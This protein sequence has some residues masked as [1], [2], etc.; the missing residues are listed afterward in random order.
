MSIKSIP[1]SE[2]RVAL[3]GAG[4]I[5]SIH[6]QALTEFAK[7]S[8]VGIVDE[9]QELRAKY[10]SKGVRSY[11]TLSE[12]AE[13]E[14]PNAVLIATPPQSRL[15]IAREAFRLGLH[16]LHEKP[17]G[18]DLAQAQAIADLAAAHP[19][20]VVSVGYCHHFVPAV[21]RCK[22][23]IESG[24]LGSICWINVDFVSRFEGAEHH[25]FLNKSLAGGGSCMG[26]TCHSIDLFIHLAG[27]VAKSSGVIQ[28]DWPGKS[29]SSDAILLQSMNGTLGTLKSSYNSSLSRAAFEIV[30]TEGTVVFNY[31]EPELLR[32]ISK[33][34]EKTEEPVESAIFR[35]VRQDQ[36]WIDAIA[37]TPQPLLA[38]VARGVEVARIIESVYQS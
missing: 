24:A 21:V 14:S 8:V 1:P 26:V 5:G 31:D 10:E 22:E 15:D 3:V 11:A 12:L 7:V 9:L 18:F 29:E 37:G 13:K 33:S 20:L 27:A 35:F 38:D 17:L 30:G 4:S 25:W 36:A 28:H 34:G 2:V 16:Q 32:R 6:Y 19:D 23:L